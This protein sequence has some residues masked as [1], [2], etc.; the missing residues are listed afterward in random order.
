MGTQ[1]VRAEQQPR[2]HGAQGGNLESVECTVAV[3]GL[4]L[5]LNV[6]W[7]PHSTGNRVGHIGV[8]DG[9]EIG[10]LVARVARGDDDLAGQLLLNRD[11]PLRRILVFAVS[12]LRAGRKRSRR[13]RQE[14]S[15]WISKTSDLSRVQRV[16]GD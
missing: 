5:D 13:S 10:A 1:V 3:V 2:A 8:S 14:W 7:E 4:I 12:V 6:L 15:D 11:A 9:L 16:C